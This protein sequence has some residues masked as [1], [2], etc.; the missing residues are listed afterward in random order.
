M[1]AM[2]YEPLR[3]GHR[4]GWLIGVLTMDLDNSNA[5]ACD[6]SDPIGAA[7]TVFDPAKAKRQ[8]IALEAVIAAAKKMREWESL[9]R[10]VDDLREERS[11]FVAWWRATV[12]VRRGERTDIH[13]ERGECLSMAHAEART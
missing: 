9:Y 8:M 10:A 1:K 12:T 6:V 2:V 5:Y 4:L 11:A 7:L 3:H 13:A